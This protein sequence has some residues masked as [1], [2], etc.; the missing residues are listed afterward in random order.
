MF[1]ISPPGWI[2][3]LGSLPA[4]PAAV[5]MFGRSGRIVPRSTAGTV[6]L[7]SMLIGAATIALIAHQ[8]VSY[9]IA[10]ATL[11]LLLVGYGVE[12]LPWRQSARRYIETIS[13]TLTSFLLVLPAVSE[14]LR[15]VRMVTRW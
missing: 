10:G 8:S 2:H 12:R 7:V 9:V 4:I 5:Y 14:T 3:T 15:R 1:G 11:V 6:Y 13:L